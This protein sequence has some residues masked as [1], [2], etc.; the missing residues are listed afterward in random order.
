MHTARCAGPEAD[1]GRGFY[2]HITVGH[3]M[4]GFLVPG[5]E[6][7]AARHAPEG[8]FRGVALGAKLVDRHRHVV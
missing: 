1:E 5:P 2:K 4:I 8:G 3:A 6:T 7:S